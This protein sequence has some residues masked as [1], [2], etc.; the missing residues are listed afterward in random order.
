MSRMQDRNL[1]QKTLDRLGSLEFSQPAT[2]YRFSIDS[3]LLA[4]FVRSRNGAAADL[5]AGCGVVSVLLNKSGLSGPF[6][7]VELNAL[8][9]ECCRENFSR[10]Q[11]PGQV[12]CQDLTRLGE[13]LP[14]QGY[15]LVVSNPPFYAVG[16]GRL[17]TDEARAKARHDLAVSPGSLCAAAARLL[18]KGG[19]FTLCFNPARLV[20]LLGRLAANGL[21]PKRLRMVHGRAHKPARLV[22]LEAV[23]GGGE[24][25]TVEPPLVVYGDGQNYSAEV[26]AM[27]DR[28]CGP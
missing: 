4:G 10:Y 26:A 28:L 2:G 15:R 16:S 23:K 1:P 22:L 24:G 13:T 11:V 21:A 3:V 17:P 14:A 20:R 19:V 7:A 9:A 6:S 18:G 12:L 8:A 27:Y 5:G 25:L